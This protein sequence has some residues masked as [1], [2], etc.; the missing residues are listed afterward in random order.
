MRT[1]TAKYCPHL[2]V[3]S[4]F[5]ET[6]DDLEEHTNKFAS[7]DLREFCAAHPMRYAQRLMQ[8]LVLEL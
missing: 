6:E 2:S 3:Q 8:M 7:T 5:L 4:Y 1:P